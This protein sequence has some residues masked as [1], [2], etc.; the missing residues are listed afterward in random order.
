[1]ARAGRKDRGLLSKRDTAGKIVWYVRLYREGRERRFGSFTTKTQAR[2]FY[3]KAK[4]EQKQGRFFPERYQHGGYAKLADVISSYMATTTKESIRDDQCHAAYWLVR[5][6]NWRLTA[7]T[8]RAL[9]Q[10]RSTNMAMKS[11][12]R[13]ASETRNIALADAS[14]RSRKTRT[15]DARF[16]ELERTLTDALFDANNLQV[17]AETSGLKV[18]SA[19]GYAR[20]GG[21]PFGANPAMINA[22]FVE[23]V[24]LNGQ[25][26]DVIEIDNNRSAVVQVKEY[27]PEARKTLDDVREEITFTL[28]SE[29]ALNMIEDRARRLSEATQEGQVF[30]IAAV[31]LEAVVTPSVI[32]GRQDEK[33]DASVLNEVFR[34]RKPSPGNARI[35]NAVTTTGDYAVFMVTAVIPGRPESIPLADRD[36]RKNDLESRA[37]AADFTAFVTELALRAD[38][39]RSDEAL[40]QQDFFQ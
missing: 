39:E 22:I 10:T 18:A 6:P 28:Q 34:V 4:Q 35:D 27:H 16:I 37:G 9:D 17:M 8:P 38:I 23:E 12:N 26:S 1:M 31:E 3:E 19:A 5:F 30:D 36:A 32:V 15:A 13:Y 21:E 33:I 24:L 40:Q 7:V 29:R 11:E 20:T 25:I 2:D 14:V